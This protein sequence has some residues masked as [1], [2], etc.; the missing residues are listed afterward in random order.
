MELIIIFSIFVIVA[1][2]FFLIVPLKKIELW[3]SAKK[4]VMRK[5]KYPFPF[6]SLGFQMIYDNIVVGYLSVYILF[7]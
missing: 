7:L 5:K 4:K 6:I 1:I 2:F 3:Q